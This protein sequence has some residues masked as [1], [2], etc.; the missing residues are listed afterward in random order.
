MCQT[1]RMVCA[2]LGVEQ[3][4]VPVLR[5]G[6]G[7]LGA[8]AMV[9]AGAPC[10]AQVQE[11]YCGAGRVAGPNER[12]P[13]STLQGPAWGLTQLGGKTCCF[14]PAGLVGMT[15]APATSFPSS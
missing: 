7:A 5:D 14:S 2:G 8:E 12:V 1:H 13:P 4:K 3:V 15:P 11:F 10:R 6:R 9:W